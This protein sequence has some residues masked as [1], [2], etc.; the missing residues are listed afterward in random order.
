MAPN[1][2]RRKTS[3]QAAV[4]RTTTCSGGRFGHAVAGIERGGAWGDKV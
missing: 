3:P 2:M 1:Q 4:Q